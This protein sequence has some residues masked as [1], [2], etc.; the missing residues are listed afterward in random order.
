LKL[1]DELDS[2]YLAFCETLPGELRTLGRQLPFR[3]KLAPRP[4]M[5]WS[6]VLAHEVTFAAPAVFAQAIP[7]LHPRLVRDAF[8]AHALAVVEAFGTDRVQ[9]A[10]VPSSSELLLVLAH[11]RSARD[12]AMSQLSVLGS[13][14]DPELDYARAGADV[15]MSIG[16]EK[17]LMTAG[18]PT[19]FVT[20]EEIVLGKTRVGIPASLAL[21]AVAGVDAK[22]RSAIRET[23]RD[24]WLG[25]QYQDDVIDWEDDLRRDSSCVVLLARGA[26]LSVPLRDRPTERDPIRKMIFESRIL[27]EMLTRA[28]RHFRSAR[29]RARALGCRDLAEWARAKEHHA[30]TV[31]A[32][33]ASSPGYAVRVHALTPWAAEV[34]A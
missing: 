27:E 8:L 34:L 32:K 5:P 21:A 26:R 2:L 10:Q 15:L 13:G 9:D 12:R 31:A 19:D 18:R 1:R 20:Y 7:G 28:C 30:R 17:E 23:L 16:R 25:M 11:L 33:E 4:E 6:Q 29:M 3:L 24:I 22:R 14:S